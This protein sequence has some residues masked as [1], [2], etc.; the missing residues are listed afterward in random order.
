[1]P[2]SRSSS[3][4]RGGSHRQHVKAGQQSHK[5]APSHQ[6][7]DKSNQS[8]G[9]RGGSHEQHVKAGQQ[10]HKNADVRSDNLEDESD[11]ESGIDRCK[12]SRMF[13]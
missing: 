1:M 5:N 6:V 12:S 8:S 2:T 4:N 3:E 13:Q 10:S 7:E 9:S 11:K